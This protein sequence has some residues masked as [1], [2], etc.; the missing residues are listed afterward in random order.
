MYKIAS[1]RAQAGRDRLKLADL[2]DKGLPEIQTPEQKLRN[3]QRAHQGLQAEVGR[4]KEARPPGWKMRAAEIGH[5]MQELQAEIAAQ[6]PKA[7]KPRGIEGHFMDIARERLGKFDYE[8]LRDA[9]IDRAAQS[10][11]SGP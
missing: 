7:K 5:R 2:A 6:K 10:E 4:I 9:A 3:L 11:E 1:E 8:R